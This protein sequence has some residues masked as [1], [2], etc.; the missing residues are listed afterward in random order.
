MGNFLL[1]CSAD[2]TFAI[3][4]KHKVGS[5]TLLTRSIFKASGNRGLFISVRVANSSGKTRRSR[6]ATK[7]HRLPFRTH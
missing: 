2:P 6:P 1:F 3:F 5:S 7:H 4:A